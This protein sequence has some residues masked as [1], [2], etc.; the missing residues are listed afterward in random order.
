M[1]AVHTM[2]SAEKRPSAIQAWS[3]STVT[4]PVAWP[5]RATY[6]TAGAATG[7]GAMARFPWVG[8]MFP[9]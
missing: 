8:N 1:P 7:G 9:A 6:H 4:G 5:P 2:L 3:W